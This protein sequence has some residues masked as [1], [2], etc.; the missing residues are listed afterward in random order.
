MRIIRGVAFLGLCSILM[1]CGGG[2]GADA[3]GA[4]TGILTSG[5]T[6]A[7]ARRSISPDMRHVVWKA[8]LANVEKVRRERA[9]YQ[10]EST[11]ATWC[12]SLPPKTND[13]SAMGFS[14]TISCPG[15]PKVFT[16]VCTNTASFS[17]TCGKTTYT[18]AAGGT[19]G[20]SWPD[21]E[22]ASVTVTSFPTMTFT[23]NMTVS[24]GGLKSGGS[25]ITM[26]MGINFSALATASTDAAGFCG[27]LVN[28]TA[29]VD[30][31]AVTCSDLADGITACSK[32]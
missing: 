13:H 32:T 26:S 9:L 4:F 19:F 28:F 25:N 23:M 22:A 11:R 27:S 15:T 20:I 3:G 18:A 31:A 24:G 14:C 8:L 5:T 17:A 16:S 29:T 21:A 30:G 6:G 10:S 12:A 1:S 2:G 7:L